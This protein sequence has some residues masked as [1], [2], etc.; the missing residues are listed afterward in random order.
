MTDDR[1]L[2]TIGARLRSARDDARPFGEAWTDALDGLDVPDLWTQRTGSG[3]D[4]IS[5]LEFARK[6]LRAAYERAGADLDLGQPTAH[7]F[8]HG[9]RVRAQPRTCR[10]GRL[11]ERPAGYGRFG[12]FCEDHAAA[13]GQ[14]RLLAGR[15]E[16]V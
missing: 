7:D 6:H 5:P 16:S 3:R 9:P 14:F 15:L 10:Y 8:A 11:C 12:S 1:L 2:E 4:D 13:V